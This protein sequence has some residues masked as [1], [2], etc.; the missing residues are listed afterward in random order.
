M[1]NSKKLTL[2]TYIAGLSGGVMVSASLFTI[3]QVTPKALR[4]TALV[5]LL[6]FLVFSVM[7]GVAEVQSAKSINHPHDPPA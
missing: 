5:A 6:I 2:L 4:L 1:L 7:R 3:I